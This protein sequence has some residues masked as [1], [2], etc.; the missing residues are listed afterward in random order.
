MKS[1][2]FLSHVADVRLKVEAD[3]LK[4]LFSAAL[5][6]MSNLIKTNIKTIEMSPEETQK[7]KIEIS[8]IDE[9]ALLID[10][11]SEV[12]TYT[13]MKK[14]V[15]FRIKFEKLT[16]NFLSA[17]IYGI[18]VDKFDEDIKAVTHHEAEIKQDIDGNL[19]TIIVF[20]I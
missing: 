12:L 11:L 16:N 9:T 7:E 6:G 15:Y 18:K 14:T 10:F 20:D 17:S 19:K 5:E 4:E 3:S 8:S 13:Q 1:Y 2:Q